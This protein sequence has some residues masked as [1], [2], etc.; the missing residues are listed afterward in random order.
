MSV[1]VPSAVPAQARE[2]LRSRAV[3]VPHHSG[4]QHVVLTCSFISQGEPAA[5]PQS[6]PGAGVRSRLACKIRS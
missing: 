5:R 3:F 6:G 1:H 2:S 4:V